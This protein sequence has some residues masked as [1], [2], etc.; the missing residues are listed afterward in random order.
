MYKIALFDVDSTLI[1]EE[2]IDL[3]AQQTSHATRVAEITERAMAGEL[4]FD[5]ALRERVALLADLPE[6]IFSE[7]QQQITFTKGAYSLIDEMKS[8]NISV[9]VVSGGFHN[10][11]N[12]LL[13]DLDLQFL[14]ANTLE[15][16]DGRLTGRT[17]GPIINRRAKAQ[18]LKDFAVQKS[19]PLT[20]TIAIGDGS[21]DI[22]MIEIS[23]LGI[24]FCGKPI[25]E[26]AADVAI[27]ERDLI[28][29]LEYLK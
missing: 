8:L 5:E 15:V 14:R 19:V 12:T 17:V 11:L 20:Q 25:L 9:G 21:N 1:N 29:I 28:K 16:A 6:S 22:E 7:V 3:L 24:S 4:D 10:V 13:H 23:G 2:V 26:A 27:R 18:A